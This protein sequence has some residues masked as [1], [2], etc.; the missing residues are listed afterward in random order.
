MSSRTRFIIFLLFATA[1]LVSAPMAILYTAGYRYNIQTGEVQQTGLVFLS[2]LPK[3]ADVLLDGEPTETRTPI[4]LKTVI[5]GTHS[6]RLQKQGYLPW[7]KVLPVESRVTTFAQDVPLFLDTE[8]TITLAATVQ[9]SAQDAV[10]EHAAYVVDQGTWWEIWSF[11]SRSE[12]EMLLARI[13]KGAGEPPELFWSKD[14]G[15]LRVG[16]DQLVSA[17]TG[18][19]LSLSELVRTPVR[20]WWDAG[21]DEEYIVETRDGS[22]FS[23]NASTGTTKELTSRAMAVRTDEGTEISVEKTGDHATVSRRSGTTSTIIA[24]IPL[25]TYTFLPSPSPYLLLRDEAT[26]H[27]LLLDG[28]GADQPIL[29]QARATLW[30]WRPDE[31]ALLY[32]DGFELHLYTPTSHRDETLTRVSDPLT[33]IAWVSPGGAVLFSQAN[34]LSALAIDPRNG[35]VTTPL[36]SGEGLRD[37]WVTEDGTAAYFFGMIQGRSGLFTRLLSS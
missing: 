20:G 34:T 11:S 33:G 16:D 29:L 13:P 26:D 2:T 21:K 27:L 17:D 32:T 24:Y 23:V 7:E 22:L 12:T 10:G 14:G 37:V 3:G 19:S 15:Y 8:A 31:G 36:Q 30:Q 25:G 28:T 9:S 1:F 18:I 6:I 35:H 5:P 4:L